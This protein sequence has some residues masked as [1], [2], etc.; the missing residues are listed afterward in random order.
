MTNVLISQRLV[1]GTISVSLKCRID[2]LRRVLDLGDREVLFETPIQDVQQQVRERFSWR[3]QLT[4]DK[5]SIIAKFLEIPVGGRLVHF[6]SKWEQITQDQWVLDIIRDG[7]KLE[8]Q[9]I[10]PFNGVKATSVP[11]KQQNL[12]KKK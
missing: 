9:K 10:P 5:V 4:N 7:Y 1:N 2:L 8:F 11:V 6:L 12:I 3:E